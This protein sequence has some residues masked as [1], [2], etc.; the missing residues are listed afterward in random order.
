VTEQS[1][2]TWAVAAWARPRKALKWAIARVKTAFQKLKRRY[3]PRYTSALVLAVIIALFVPVPGATLIVV[4]LVVIVA[5]I[6]RTISRKNG[7]D[8]A[9]GTLSEDSAMAINCDLIVQWNAT[10]KELT[11][12]G[13]A[14]WR[15][16]NHA[17]GKTGIYQYIDNQPL[18]DLI[19]GQFPRSSQA[20]D[21]ADPRGAHFGFRDQISHDRQTTI[22][23]LRREIPAEVI[24]DVV[25][26]GLSCWRDRAGTVRT[27]TTMAGGP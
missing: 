4:A 14:L 15:W 3:G 1:Q 7:P 12:L 5:E 25:V 8:K 18:A 22:D 24:E 2:Q 21:Q 9:V 26:D 27:T 19:A 17:S 10:P 6:H 13:T 11:T 20:R 23:S 16:C